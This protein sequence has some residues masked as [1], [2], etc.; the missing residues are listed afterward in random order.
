MIKAI[1]ESK[2]HVMLI[3]NAKPTNRMEF[4]M[5]KRR[6]LDGLIIPLGISLI[7]VRGFFASNSLSRYLL[8]AIAALRAK[9]MQAIM[10]KNIK[11]CVLVYSMTTSTPVM[12]DVSPDFI[13]VYTPM[14]NPIRANGIA[15]MVCENLMRDK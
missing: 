6:A 5:V 4:R 2:K 13:I 3:M 9:T 10:Y 8:K 12:V 1:G 7:A 11:R 15:K 14:K